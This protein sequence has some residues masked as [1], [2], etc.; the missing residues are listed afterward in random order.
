MIHV[1]GV[2]R[3]F[4]A[5]AT[6]EF[7]EASLECK[8]NDTISTRFQPFAYD[9]RAV[10]AKQTPTVFKQMHIMP[11]RCIPAGCKGEDAIF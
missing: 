2:L 9:M 10:R 7:T 1:T 8:I 11:P 3:E 5:G 4:L 6:I